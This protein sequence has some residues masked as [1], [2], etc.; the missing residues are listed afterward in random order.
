MNNQQRINDFLT[1]WSKIGLQNPS[2][3][4]DTKEA[5]NQIYHELIHLGVSK[6]DQ[7]VVLSSSNPL[8]EIENSFQNWIDYYKDND[9]I[10]VFN[11]PYWKYFCQFVST[12]E[13]ATDKKEHIKVYVPLDSAHI[14]RGA[15]MIFNFLTDNN[16]SH[17]SKI[18]KEIRFD[19]IVIRLTNE[20]DT[21]KLLNFIT[22]NP[23]LQ[24]GLIKP[25]PFA[26]QQNGIAM[27]CDG[28]ESYNS[29]VASTIAMY[30]D[31]N[32]KNNRL[33][34]SSYQDFYRFIAERYKKEF[35]EK[36]E[37]NFEK[38]L[39]IE[40]EEK[41]LNFQ[42]IIAL[43]LKCQNPDFNLNNYFDHFY[44]S[45]SS[46][47][48]KK[49]D[50]NLLLQELSD[51]MTKKYGKEKANTNINAY[52]RTGNPSYITRDNNLRERVQKVSL[53]IEIDNALKEK[54][55][56]FDEYMKNQSSDEEDACEQLFLLAVEEMSKKR[57]SKTGPLYVKAYL[58]TGQSTYLT[59]DNNLRDLVLHSNM[60]EKINRIMALSGQS[61]EEFLQ[62][63]Q[64]K[65]YSSKRK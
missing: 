36:Q 52:L 1:Y 4:F 9:K 2:Y 56:I 34:Q 59:R 43:M 45:L 6:E 5:Q 35:I 8:S 48:Q 50:I 16:I 42:Y 25:N 46:K 13:K 47:E 55:I 23:Y 21:R 14:Q 15:K 22:N 30:L 53:N 27:A 33:T 64:E 28:S 29:T 44:Q 61:F 60:R 58:Q 62:E 11:P 7:N 10:L 65:H 39:G 24:E 41:R 51:T 26:F 63:V 20:N 3:S 57:N 18:G 32:K 49:E 38:T 54:Q 37:H 17:T 19:D 12:K 40:T 31:Y